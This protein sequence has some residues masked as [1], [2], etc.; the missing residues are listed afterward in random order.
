MRTS[1]SPLVH[2]T[3]LTRKC[4]NHSLSF[5]FRTT[6]FITRRN[7]NT[8][9]TTNTN[10]TPNATTRNNNN[11]KSSNDKAH[12][13]QSE[14]STIHH[15]IHSSENNNL[16]S[17]IYNNYKTNHPTKVM[18]H[19]SRSE[20]DYYLY[21]NVQF[22]FSIEPS[23]SFISD[24]V[25]NEI[26]SHARKG[27]VRKVLELLASIKPSETFSIKEKEEIDAEK[28]LIIHT[29]M[30]AYAKKGD[31]SKTE[32][33]F[34]KLK[35]PDKK[36][37]TILLGAYADKGMVENAEQLF[38]K[39]TKPDE[40]CY[41]ELMR[42]YSKKGLFHKIQE[43]YSS[44][45]YKLLNIESIQKKNNDESVG[46]IEST[47]SDHTFENTNGIQKGM[48]PSEHV[49]SSSLLMDLCEMVKT[50]YVSANRIQMDEY[51]Y[52][53]QIFTVVVAFR[54]HGMLKNKEY[55][56]LDA[57]F[58]RVSKYIFTHDFTS[59]SS[60]K[61]NTSTL[62]NTHMNTNNNMNTNMNT[63]MNTNMNTHINTNM[64]THINTNTSSN[65][66]MNTHINTNTSSNNSTMIPSTISQIPK[67]H[68]NILNI[69]L[70]SLIQRKA[71]LDRIESFVKHYISQPDTVT[72]HSL[73]VYYFELNMHDKVDK[74]FKQISKLEDLDTKTRNYFASTIMTMLYRHGI[75]HK[76]EKIFRQ[77]Q[78]PDYTCYKILMNTYI[79]QRD[80]YKMM[81]LFKEIPNDMIDD[82]L[83]A[84][85]MAMR[86]CVVTKR[87]DKQIHQV[88]DD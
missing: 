40:A 77:I 67:S 9:T 37:F 71:P 61:M 62:I 4:F 60:T 50:E 2:S 12:P 22:N 47:T 38:S 29:L 34:R 3:S 18:T 46:T 30:L 69:Y 28:D 39:I 16:T 45:N 88:V 10:H 51:E 6:S 76:V 70:Q 57:T 68:I 31:V 54:M 21:K 8:S 24:T 49:S 33:L 53:Q 79:Q 19:P 78:S 43:H 74:L 66:N 87:V 73:L 41:V 32:F 80:T 58:K 44:I 72:Y 82:Q 55:G 35:S 52:L 59:S 48:N 81:Q 20:N 14:S 26:L 64:N 42:T 86:R 75:Y 5:Q 23:K 83:V 1:T 65:N 84:D 27:D 56:L 36:C 17:R 13:Q 15:S 85:M 63:H 11:E 7:I 25:R